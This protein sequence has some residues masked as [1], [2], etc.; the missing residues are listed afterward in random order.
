MIASDH[1]YYCLSRLYQKDDAVFHFSK[2]KYVA[3]TL[4][5]EREAIMVSGAE[6]TAEWVESTIQSLKPGFELALH[7]NVLIKNRTHH[8]PMIDFTLSGSITFDVIDRMRCFLPRSVMLNLA[9]YESGRSFHAYSTALIRPKDWIEFMG[10]LL[11]INSNI[12]PDII[13]TRW[14]GHR[15]IGGFSSLRWSNNTKQY[16]G[17]PKRIRFPA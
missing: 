15:L 10:R 12:S 7:S 6:L 8:I 1:P 3:D 2:Y 17:M 14:I 9:I 4:F 11:L 16:L 5:D 13:D